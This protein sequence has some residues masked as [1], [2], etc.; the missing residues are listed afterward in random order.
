VNKLINSIR[1][2]YNK[3]KYSP[4]GLPNPKDSDIYL[5]SYPKSGN[6]WLRYLMAQ[7]I[8]P[9]LDSPD[10]K[11][12]AAY[13]PSYGLLEDI[14]FMK[15][16]A[17]PCNSLSHRLIKHHTAYNPDAE[18]HMKMAIYLLR[19]GRDALVSYWHFCNQRDSTS[20]PFEEF[21]VAS[22]SKPGYYGPWQDHVDG[23][24]NSNTRSLLVIRYEDMLADPAATLDKALKFSGLSIDH[25]IIERAVE[26][27][28]FD[29][30]KRIE[31]SKGMGREELSRV[32]FVRSGKS[33]GWK[34]VFSDRAVD[35]FKQY[36]AHS[37]EKLG[38]YW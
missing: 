18:R 8:W 10:L 38:Y 4:L 14:G 1:F 15:D 27:S 13:I 21:L 26:K 6:T 7:A 34:N 2:R 23:W 36:H 31:K 35:I 17:A 24:I 22:A 9:E 30:M 29:A 25:A 11:N 20:V 12:L 28:A 16:L 3:A 19:D 32:N 5:V 37:I 33:G